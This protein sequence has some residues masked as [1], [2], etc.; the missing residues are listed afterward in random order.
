MSAQRMKEMSLER[1][2]RIISAYGADPAHW[3]EAERES[4]ERL[5]AH[6]PVARDLLIRADQ[7]DR[8][9]SRV[10]ADV[11]DAAVARLAAATAFPPPRIS[12]PSLLDRL[13]YLASA[14]W[15]RATVLAGMAALGIVAGLTTEPVY[16]G[17]DAGTVVV[18]DLTADMDIIEELAP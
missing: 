16:S 6:S 8:A 14:F 13:A 11:P 17:S 10:A 15:P 1:L 4:A 2:E 5:M 7:L 9:L 3:P 12:R 18:G